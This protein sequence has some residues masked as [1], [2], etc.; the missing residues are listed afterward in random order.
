MVDDSSQNEWV[1]SFRQKSTY[2][3]TW[4][5]ASTPSV[6]TLMIFLLLFES[7]CVVT[8]ILTV[9]DSRSDVRCF[10]FYVL[11]KERKKLMHTHPFFPSKRVPFSLS[12]TTILHVLYHLCVCV[13]C[14]I[15]I[16][17]SCTPCTN[18]PH[19][20]M[21]PT[22]SPAMRT[23]AIAPNTMPGVANQVLPNKRPCACIV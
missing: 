10:V 6:R 18:K 19:K 8:C 16:V 12:F 4:K 1:N 5:P 9:Y 23:P 20:E 22:H 13:Y 15:A 11:L 2:M 14:R 17:S 21:L 3:K 7:Y